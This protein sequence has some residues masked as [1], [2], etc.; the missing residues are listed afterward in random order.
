MKSLKKMN[1]AGMVLLAFLFMISC[2]K[3]ESTDPVDDQFAQE[4][5]FETADLQGQ[6]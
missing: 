6:R 4:E 5:T 2:D 1:F 3:N